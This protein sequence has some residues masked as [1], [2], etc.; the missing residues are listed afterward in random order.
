MGFFLLG[1]TR[2]DGAVRLLS[3][4]LFDTRQQALDQLSELT[5]AQDLESEVFVVDLDNAAPVLVLQSK[6]LEASA[7]PEVAPEIPDEAQAL[8]LVED[9]PEADE[10]IADVEVE[11]ETVVE[12]EELPAEAETAGVW[13]TPVEPAIAEA[14]LEETEDAAELAEDQPDLASALKRA[15]GA[16]EDSGIVTP[17]SIGGPPPVA[18]LGNDAPAAWPWDVA[19]SPEPDQPLIVPDE[20]AFESPVAEETPFVLDPLEEPATDVSDL[21]M[22]PSGEDVETRRPVIMGAYDEAPPV[23]DAPVQPAGLLEAEEA[24]PTAPP[25]ADEPSPAV[26]PETGAPDEPGLPGPE[27]EITSVLA[28]LEVAEPLV[29]EAGGSDLAEMTCEDCVYMNTCPKRG[30]SD[31]TTCGSFQWKSG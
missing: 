18:A 28:D 9:E 23:P 26:E 20:P 6:P 15:T 12:S 25:I 3:D 21:V 17:D 16:L 1:R 27:D 22:H 14:V 7:A 24:L 29:Y 2:S 5:V 19:P 30:E 4:Q 31:P 8:D 10:I 13:E 11:P